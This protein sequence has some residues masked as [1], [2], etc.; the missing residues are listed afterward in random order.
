M[1]KKADASTNLQARLL[2]VREL[3]GYT[4]LG[5]TKA[6]EFGVKAGARFQYGN[7]VLY[8]RNRIDDY[9]DQIENENRQ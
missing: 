1:I 4:G 8:D 7:R 3:M 2:G 9:I 5:I 6:I